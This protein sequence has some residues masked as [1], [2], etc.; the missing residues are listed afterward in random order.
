MW[1][2][3]GPGI[4]PVSPV[5]AGRFLAT[6]PPGKPFFS[7][8]LS[9]DVYGPAIPVPANPH[10][11]HWLSASP[12]WGRRRLRDPI[13]EP[14]WGQ[15]ACQAHPSPSAP[16]RGESFSPNICDKWND[17]LARQI[18]DWNTTG[19]WKVKLRGAGC[20]TSPPSAEASPRLCGCW[21]PLPITCGPQGKQMIQNDSDSEWEG[22]IRP[23]L[24]KFAKQQRKTLMCV[25]CYFNPVASCCIFDSFEELLR[26]SLVC[27]S[28]PLIL[29]GLPCSYTMAWMFTPALRLLASQAD[30]PLQKGRP[31]PPVTAWL[32]WGKGLVLSSGL[33]FPH[34][35]FPVLAHHLLVHVFRG[36]LGGL[37]T[38]KG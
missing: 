30:F 28:D 34:Q 4:K 21:H 33:T 6:E 10:G 3:P 8:F 18:K 37:S 5:L 35:T 13:W 2:L 22:E 17:A 29:A 38:F 26:L 27:R 15:G 24:H 23:P 14:W 16:Y 1:D 19:A 20:V 36:S 7:C 11:C 9:G 12:T 31:W 25:P 32:L